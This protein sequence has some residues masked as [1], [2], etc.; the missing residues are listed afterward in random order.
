MSKFRIRQVPSGFKFDLKAPNGR[1][2]FTSEVYT[3]AA[4]CR[5]GIASVRAHAPDAAL[6]D[7]TEEGWVNRRNPKFELYRDKGGDF[8]FRLKARN[9]KVIGISDGYA[10]RTGALGGVDSVMHSAAEAE[11][12]E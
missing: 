4:A 12:E 10:T 2:V 5:K 11:I 3:T 6:E 8:R 7:R 1:V 9:G